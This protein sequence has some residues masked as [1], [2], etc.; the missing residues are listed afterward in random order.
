MQQRITKCRICGHNELSIVLNLGTQKL[1]GIFPKTKEQFIT[2]GPVELVKCTHQDG[3]GLVQ[4]AHRYDIDEFYGENYGY[5]SGLNKSMVEHLHSKVKKVLSLV[6]LNKDEIVVDIGSN[7]G[8]TLG[9]YPKNLSLIGIDPSGEK[10]KEYYA[11]HV[12]LLSDFFS[13]NTFLNYSKNKKA[14]VITSFSM[15]YDLEDPIKFMQEIELSLAEDGIWVFEQSYMPLMLERNSYDTVC[16]EHI[17]YYALKQI[18][19]MCDKVGLKIIDIEFNDINGGSFSIVAAK[20]NSTYQENKEQIDTILN[21]EK[22]KGLDTTKPWIEFQKRIDTEKESL[23]KFLD[24][25]K[26]EGKK[27]YGLGASTKGNVLLQYCGITPQQITAIGEVNRDKYG[28]YTPATLIPI[29]SEDEALNSDAEYF[30]VLPWH[31]KEFFVTNPKFKNKK[32][33]FP[34]PQV[35]VVTIKEN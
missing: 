24:N 29:V 4:I 15:F 31:F 5:R 20:N 27:V 18:K 6:S 1:T 21:D 7:D 22:V 16:Q 11:S 9:F 19:W 25:C 28:C 2:E 30:L 13:A 10:F 14:K 3:C 8:T 12:D 35:H 34:L 33:L 32:L 17:E 26:R 23:I